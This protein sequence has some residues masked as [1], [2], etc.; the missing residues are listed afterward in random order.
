MKR[1]G[2]VDDGTE[3]RSSRFGDIL[4]S[5]RALTFHD[6]VVNVGAD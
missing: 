3:D 2:M 1:S 5:G 6:S 4:D